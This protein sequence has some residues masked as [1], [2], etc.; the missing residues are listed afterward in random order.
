[1]LGSISESR[2][3]SVEELNDMADH[4]E[5]RKAEDALKY[6]TE[7]I[8]RDFVDF[9]ENMFR[10]SSAINEESLKDERCSIRLSDMTWNLAAF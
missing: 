9:S 8:M 1:M 5:I 10:A 4:L 6:G 7:K 3:M 2:G